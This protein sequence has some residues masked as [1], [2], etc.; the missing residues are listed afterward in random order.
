MFQVKSTDAAAMILDGSAY[1]FLN[2][3][4]LFSSGQVLEDVSD[5]GHAVQTYLDLQ[6]LGVDL[7]NGGSVMLGTQNAA[8]NNS[9]STLWVTLR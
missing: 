2:R 1:A 5:Y 3:F 4:S 7:G 6:C 8:T 9:L